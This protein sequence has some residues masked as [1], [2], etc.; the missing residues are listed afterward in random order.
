MVDCE[1]VRCRFDETEADDIAGCERGAK[2]VGCVFDRCL[3]RVSVDE[4]IVY[5][6]AT[7][8]NVARG[9]LSLLLPSA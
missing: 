4:L 5:N 3:H 6:L 9:A 1:S 8:G 2:I 7:P